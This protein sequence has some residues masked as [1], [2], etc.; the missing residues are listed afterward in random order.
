MGARRVI[1]DSAMEKSESPRSSVIVYWRITYN[2]SQ[3]VLQLF[4][5]MQSFEQSAQV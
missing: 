5:S 2:G 1:L 3:K 4:D